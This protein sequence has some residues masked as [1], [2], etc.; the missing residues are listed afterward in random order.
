MLN[1]AF[2]YVL[3]LSVGIVCLYFLQIEDK[4]PIMIGWMI[5]VTIAYFLGNFILAR[6]RKKQGKTNIDKEE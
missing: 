1:H 5:G 2:R 4:F 6:L 3:L